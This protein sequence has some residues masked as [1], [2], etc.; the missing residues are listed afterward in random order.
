MMWPVLT[1]VRYELLGGI[2]SSRAIWGQLAISLVA[3]WL[4][5]PAV[6]VR[7]HLPLPAMLSL[8]KSIS[9]VASLP[10]ASLPRQD[11]GLV[12]KHGLQI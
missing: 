1:K 9:S 4:L 11:A 10:S 6:M 3:N 12:T 2:L 8:L 7:I 5:G